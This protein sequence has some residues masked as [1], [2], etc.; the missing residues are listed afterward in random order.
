MV[1]GVT[2]N[3]FAYFPQRWEGLADGAILPNLGAERWRWIEAPFLVT[4]FLVRAL[5]IARRERPAVVNAHWILPSGLIALVVRRLLGIPYVLTVHG[6][7]THALNGAVFRALKRKVVAGAHTVTPV[8][9]EIGELLGLPSDELERLVVPMGVDVAGIERESVRRSPQQ[10]RFLFIGRLAEKKGADVLL[11]ALARVS[12]ARLVI[13]GGGP[14]EV[15]L[16][17]LAAK[18][19]IEH[20]VEFL[21]Q[22]SSGRVIEEMRIAHALVI[23]SKVARDG[24]RDGTPVVMAEAM[25]AGVPIVAS[26]LG[27][28][29]EHIRSGESGLL[30]PPGSVSSLA[31]ALQDLMA[32]NYDLRR[33]VEGARR[34]LESK[35]DLDSTGRRYREFISAA[36]S[37]SSVVE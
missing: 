13:L 22:R 3:R 29:G 5:L 4:G 18:L 25:A 24:D 21:G 15:H 34:Q 23:P 36:T 32:G 31:A 28:L 1:D 14:E 12:G 20:R 17:S 10:G 27:G 33:W 30:V 19:E 35:L 26:D 16:R 2:I 6:A 11:E 8:S 37:S 7:D 9:R